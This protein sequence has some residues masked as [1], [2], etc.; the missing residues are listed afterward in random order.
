[1]K[2]II[3]GATG[4]VGRGVLYECLEDNRIE[5]VLMINRSSLDINHPKLE[6]ALLKDFTEVEVIKDRLLGYD[7][8]FYCMGISAVGL[9]EEEY[10]KITYDTANAFAK[11]LFDINQ[12]LIF[13]YVSGTGTDETEKGNSMWARVKGKTENMLLKK[14]FKDAIMFR[15]GFIIPE[16]GIKSKTNWYNAFYV[17]TRPL[18]PLMK[19]SKQI[20]TTTNIG[21]AMINSLFFP[22]KLK[23]LEN[24]MINNLSQENG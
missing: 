19:K 12:E 23:H 15:P 3:T 17:I 20:T 13:N 7:A 21:K 8:C 6:E 14:G 9:S 5:K 16:K 18:F 22:P 1:M 24:R 2:V 11:T 10:T 4:M